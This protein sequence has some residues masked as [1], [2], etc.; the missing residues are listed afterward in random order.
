MAI[1][2]EN[3]SVPSEVANHPRFVEMVSPDIPKHKLLRLI[4]IKVDIK[5]LKKVLRLIPIKGSSGWMKR[6]FSSKSHDMSFMSKRAA[7][8]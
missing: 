1:G 4:P 3:L 2:R 7:S 5:L 6:V 8:W